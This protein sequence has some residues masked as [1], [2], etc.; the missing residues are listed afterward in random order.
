M[1]RSV[2]ATYRTPLLPLLGLV[3][4]LLTLAGLLLSPQAASSQS[5]PT[6]IGVVVSSNA[7]DDTYLLGET[8]SITLTFSE[9][10]NVTGA[11]RL[12][13]DMDPA[14]WGEKWASYN[15]G[16]GTAS[17][18]FAHTVVEPNLSTQGIAVLENTLGLN[19]GT[20]RSAASQTD[21]DLSHTGLDHNARHKVDW[22]RSPPAPTPTPT[23]APTPTPTPSVTEVAV[24]SDAGDDNTYLLGETIRITLTFSETVDVSGAP[25]L[26]IDMDPAEWGEKQ[27]GYDNGSGTAS[28]T[29]AHTVVEPNLSTQGIAVLADTLELNGGSI[30]SVAAQIDADLSH[31]GLDHNASHK[32]DWRQSP[33]ATISTVTDVAVSSDA[34][35]DDTYL[36][37][38]T[39]RITLTF[40]ETVNV[41]GAP[42][43]KIDMDPAEWGEK[44]T[45]YHSGS[46]TA[47][48]TFTHTVVEP[49]ISTQGIAVLADTLELNG[50][51]IQ[52][53]S[54]QTDADLSH[55]G[56]AHDASHKVDWRRSPGQPNQA[57]VV[58]TQAENYEWF[59]SQQNIPR[60]LLFSKSFYQVFTDPDG[61]ELTYS[62]SAS[63]DHR[64]L[65]D[66]LSIGLDYRTPENSHQP[67][68]LFHR[69]WFE[70][71]G[72]DDWKGISPA[73]SDPVVVTATLTATDPEGLSVSLDS[74]IL[75]DWESHPEVV[76][77]TASEQAIALTFDVAV[78]ADPAPTAGQFTVNVVNG[79]GTTGT[80]SVSGVTVNG[81]VVTLG[82]ASELAEGQAATLDYAHHDDTPLKRDSDGGDPAP[83]FQGQAVDTSQL[84]L[85]GAVANF[86]M[87]AEPGELDVLARWDAVKGATSYKLRWRESGGT[88]AAADVASVSGAAIGIITVSSYGRWEVRVQGCNNDGCGLEASGTVDVVP[89]ASL[90][91]ERAVDAEGQARPR[92][93]TATWDPVEDATSY[94]LR[95][96]PANEN[97]PAPAQP[98]SN[99]RQTRSIGGRGAS[100][101]TQNQLTVPGDQT[102]ADIA[103]PDERV[104][105]VDLQARGDGN[106]IIAQGDA[107]VGQMSG[108]PDTTPPTIVRG[109]INGNRMTVYFSEALDEDHAW[110]KFTAML[111]YPGSFTYAD[112]SSNMVV[113]GNAVTV[114]FED[115]LWAVAGLTVATYY[116]PDST[117]GR[118]LRDLAGN[119]V[120]TPLP[121]YSLG[122]CSTPLI[123]LA[124]V[125]PPPMLDSV[126]AYPYW[127]ALAVDHRLDRKIGSCGQ[128]VHRNG[129][130]ER[131]QTGRL[132]TRER[133]RQHRQA[134]PGRASVGHRRIDGE[135]CQ[136]VFGQQAPGGG[137]RGGGLRR[138]RRDQPGGCCTGGEGGGH[139]LDPGRG[140]DL[141]PRR[142]DPGVADLHRGGD[143]RWHAAA[144]DQDAHALRAEVDRLRRR[145]WLDHADLLLYREGPGPLHPRHRGTGGHSGTERRLDPVGGHAAEE[146]APVVRRAGPQR[147]PQGG[148][149]AV[150]SGS[151]LGDRCGHHFRPGR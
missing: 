116:L 143:R 113:S 99:A 123:Y 125:T 64:Q 25:R 5:A 103:V 79:D 9:T 29:F 30:Q 90:R 3:A 105:R 74:G 128:R 39:I 117:T 133:G 142:D 56:L 18:T 151:P 52:S 47:S 100:T 71:D 72:E 4:I 140:P 11:P 16:S 40:S 138:P 130:R 43:L 50:G 65:L 85:P 17:L 46:G 150:Y 122:I 83:G 41:T 139:H 32:V 75:I 8:V 148:L 76:S 110:G 107:G 97:P 147:R 22:R 115:H 73:L 28:L 93:L 26:K 23:P 92:T 49:N 19:G 36:L 63:E 141:R 144:E 55:T 77:T 126:E 101:Q 20:I 10:V 42:Q 87:L 88:F 98:A 124:N 54:S 132:S 78:E 53:V 104:Y 108:Q 2:I 94:L 6:V 34:G 45:G 84:G 15:S 59:T 119:R 33:P 61:D 96:W 137:Q 136:T 114:D 131:G 91:L 86:S 38:E 12:K 58:D 120:S 60:G 80:V 44:W 106:Q 1:S 48:L 111:I 82:L 129:E 134:G 127:V 145:Q 35:D 112:F 89:A 67:M 14:D 121:W 31:T 57:P 13:I 66:D 95:W 37:G 70:V 69:V 135:L 149:A 109:E 62:V 7:G 68:E 24:S 21:A 102:G 118:S 27:A 51:S 81:A 146:R